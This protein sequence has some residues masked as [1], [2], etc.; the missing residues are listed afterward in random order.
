MDAE[1]VPDRLLA[2]R[3]ISMIFPLP[4]HVTPYHVH[5][6]LSR[7]RQLFIVQLA[8]SVSLYRSTSASH[9]ET[10]MVVTVVQ[11]NAAY[12][13]GISSCVRSTYRLT[14]NPKSPINKSVYPA[15]FS[16]DM[17]EKGEVKDYTYFIPSRAV[18]QKR[19]SLASKSD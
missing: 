5:G 15:V 7:S 18:L 8:P 3:F 10:G 17:R 12:V 1:S 2:L 4:L 14:E 6:S 19:H 9:S 16:P 11:L 13:S